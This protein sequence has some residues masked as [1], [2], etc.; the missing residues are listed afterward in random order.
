MSEG[1]FRVP[2][3]RLNS[4]PNIFFI[5]FNIIFLEKRQVFLLKAFDPMMFFPVF[6]VRY[7]F[8]HLPCA[9][10]KSAVSFLPCEIIQRDNILMKPFGRTWIK[11][12]I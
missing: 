8:R 11:I 2:Q 1:E 10:A 9:N 5:V 6:D 7:Y 12:D 3:G 4:S